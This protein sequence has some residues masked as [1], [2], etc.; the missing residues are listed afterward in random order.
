MM[1]AEYAL[2]VL[3]FK[4]EEPKERS[5]TTIQGFPTRE[6]CEDA[7][8]QLRDQWPTMAVVTKCV[9]VKP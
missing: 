2:V 9:Q 3:L 8:K 1:E 4:Y 6:A 7:G 5:L